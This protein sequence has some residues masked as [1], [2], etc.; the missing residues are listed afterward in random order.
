MPLPEGGNRVAWPP[1]EAIPELRLMREHDAWYSGDPG[2]IAAFYDQFVTT[3]SG[4]SPGWWRFH[5]RNSI[6]PGQRTRGVLHVP[7]PGEIASVNAAML[8]GEPPKIV[9]P[10]AHEEAPVAAAVATE[11]RLLYL[12]ERGDLVAR[13]ADAAEQSAAIG[14][15]YLKVVWDQDLA[16]YPFVVPQ[17]ADAAIP[18]FQWNKLTA[19]TFWRVVD[20]VQEKVYRHLERH[21]KG[22]VLHGLYEGTRDYLGNQVAL[23][24]K[25]ATASFEAVI[26]LPFA[27]DFLVR[28][29]PNMR[30]NRL[31]R[32][33]PLGRS[34][35]SGVEGIFD[36]LDEVY[37]SWVRDIRLAKARIMVPQEYLKA[38]PNSDGSTSV[39]FDP[40][41]EAFTPLDIEPGQDRTTITLSQFAIRS[42][43]HEQTALALVE[44]AA[45]AA[46]YSPQTFGL[47]IEGRADSGT[48]L[49]LRERRTQIT[50]ERK[51]QLW[52]TPLAS[53]LH[54]LLRIDASVF[55]SG[56]DLNFR[57]TV[58]IQDG[59][60]DDEAATA[61]T[62]EL[63]S[64]AG[65]AS[66]ETMV[67]MIHPEWEQADVDAEV[68]R[69]RDDQGAML[70][71]PTTLG[72]PKEE[73]DDGG[74]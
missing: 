58:D 38:T 33:S 61:A 23:T 17:Q 35:Y 3:D 15:V 31:Y 5:A 74:S 19:V 57:P 8:F 2:R 44:R 6:N 63:L 62:V 43:E 18:E 40:D 73:G 52:N 54:L 51:A 70:P 41:Q 7:I 45:S 29:V 36:S 27:D 24:G 55:N 65:A 37:S 67:K 56:V 30:P 20:E 60:P 10:E 32:D 39:R 16:D 47:N 13:L 48:A 53:I 1:R 12:A 9:I 72:L 25:E 69:I 59:L 68:Q 21:E 49:R 26:K 50:R 66:A 34:D 64:R 71:D 42:V 4:E 22:Y 28:Y 14:G 46:G 11:E